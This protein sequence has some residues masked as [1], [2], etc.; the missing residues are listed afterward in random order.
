VLLPVFKHPLQLGGMGHWVLFAVAPSSRSITIYDSIRRA[1]PLE[2]EPYATAVVGWLQE[3]W[4]FGPGEW[5]VVIDQLLPQQ[6]DGK[7]CGVF[8][9]VAA[10]SLVLGEQSS[11]LTTALAASEMRGSMA[12]ELYTQKLVRTASAI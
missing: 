6:T 11:S 1:T 2:Y 8:M 12:W 10:R 5:R 9:C 7:Q 4:L 3:E